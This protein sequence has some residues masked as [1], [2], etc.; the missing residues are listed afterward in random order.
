MSDEKE[1]LELSYGEKVKAAFDTGKAHVEELSDKLITVNETGA[2]AL[3]MEG[4][5][6]NMVS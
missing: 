6:A 4:M 5:A 2:P 3:T 1:K